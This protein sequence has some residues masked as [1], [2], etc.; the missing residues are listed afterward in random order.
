MDRT[1]VRR[2]GRVDA[3]HVPL[4]AADM[5]LLFQS[6]MLALQGQCNVWA[7]GQVVCP[8][9]FRHRFAWQAPLGKAAPVLI[10]SARVPITLIGPDRRNEYRD[11]VAGTTSVLLPVFLKWSLRDPVDEVAA[12][13]MA[14]LFREAAHGGDWISQNRHDETDSLSRLCLRT[15]LRPAVTHRQSRNRRLRDKTSEAASEPYDKDI[16]ET[17]YIA[18]LRRFQETGSVRRDRP[19]H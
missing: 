9:Y 2:L 16:G 10:Q 5:E 19:G 7:H 12:G 14:Q 13:S 4:G 15:G 17:E 8:E 11:R 1:V 3:D 6:G 18:F